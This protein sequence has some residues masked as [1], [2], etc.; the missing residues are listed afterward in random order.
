MIMENV[1]IIWFV[2]GAIMVALEA[3]LLPGIGLLFS[4]FAAITTGALLIMGLIP[5]ENTSAQFTAFF[6]ATAFWAIALWKPL[7]AYLCKAGSG[8]YH[9]IV[10]SDAVIELDDLQPGKE[11]QVKW[12]GTSMVAKLHHDIHQPLKRGSVVEIIEIAG[13]VLIVKP[14]KIEE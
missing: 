14:K 8:K 1:M 10:G 3:F 2:A 5:V 6:I 12:S 4:G 13:N 9:N 7:K 11:G